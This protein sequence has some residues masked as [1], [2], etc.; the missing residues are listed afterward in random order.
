LYAVAAIAVTLLLPI[1]SMATQKQ[2]FLPSNLGLPTP[3]YA[4]SSYEIAP[5]DSKGGCAAIGGTFFGTTCTF[6]KTLTQSLGDLLTVDS[7]VTLSL[8][9]TGVIGN[10]FAGSG[11]QP[12]SLGTIMNNGIILNR[13]S[14]TFGILNNTAG[15]AISNY[16]M[17]KSDAYYSNLY[18]YGTISNHA[19]GMVKISLGTVIYNFYGA[20][21]NNAGT[22][23]DTVGYPG[24]SATFYNTG[25]INNL[26]GG[27][28]FN[29][30]HFVNTNDGIIY[31]NA[32]ANI[33]N[34]Y[35]FYQQ[36]TILNRG[37]F[38]NNNGAD[39][40]FTIGGVFI[41]QHGGVINNNH[42]I[43]VNSL[44]IIANLYGSTINN[45]SGAILYDLSGGTIDNNAG[46]TINNGGTLEVHC[47]SAY[48]NGGT[49]TGNPITT[50]CP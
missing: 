20:V 37:N 28:V 10:N 4:S 29:Y 44:G 13:G 42:T 35:I 34:G 3:A 8:T 25:T 22:F 24:D 47:G 46:A 41:N 1:G 21:M 33:T 30:F 12:S 49:L 36:G 40:P 38:N 9:A 16:R 39:V 17:I 14:I 5:G 32:G 19:H 31:N 45:N 11:A 15:G 6:S 43:D 27:L 2:T 48:N 7:G 50:P 23:T 26:S 18:N